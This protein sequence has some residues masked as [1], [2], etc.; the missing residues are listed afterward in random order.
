MRAPSILACLLLVALVCGACQR[1]G[2]APSVVKTD[3]NAAA[4]AA[5]AL[6]KNLPAAAAGGNAGAPA[7]CQLEASQAAQPLASD[8]TKQVVSGPHDWVLALAADA[9]GV[10][11]AGAESA[12]SRQAQPFVASFAKD[13][14][15]LWRVVV[16]KGS[17][18]NKPPRAEALAVARAPAHEVFVVSRSSQSNAPGYDVYLTGLDESG[19]R[20]FAVPLEMA[21]HAPPVLASD[22][23][24]NALVVGIFGAD[25]STRALA[26][27]KY[28]SAGVKLWS[29]RYAY[30]GDLPR[31]SVAADGHLALAASLHG[32]V[33]LGS[34][35]L[36]H[37]AELRFQCADQERACEAPGRALWV[38][39][40]DADGEPVQ[41][42]IFGAPGNLVGVS[43]LARWPDGRLLVTGEI[44]GP[45][46]RLGA[47]SLCELKP[48]MPVAEARAFHEA[49]NTEADPC[50]CL[51]QQRDLFVLA[52]DS[53]AE[54]S[55]AKTLALGLPTP[56][57]GIGAGGNIVW[58]AQTSDAPALDQAGGAPDKSSLSLWELDAAGKVL[59]RRSAEAGGPLLMASAADG[60][61]YLVSGPSLRR[62]T[63]SQ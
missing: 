28:S 52:L 26:V 2:R 22:A 38:A 3:T 33:Q 1:P 4:G 14:R 49:G 34:S 10:V 60:N 32:A 12:A 21:G 29:K 61:V 47:L 45:A 31:L 51:K 56:S 7:E 30:S 55:W 53:H 5:P 54:P 24:G 19:R 15:Q 35:R 57:V 48:G 40:L 44:Y 8:W 20:V 13:G 41:S 16:D 25:E 62:I 39:E 59:R 18:G 27:V 42:R 6:V 58:A 9:T 43:S 37:Q 11:V 36:E 63:V 23:Q 17:I 46:L 50:S